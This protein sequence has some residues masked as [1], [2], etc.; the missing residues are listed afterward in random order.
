MSTG[1]PKNMITTRFD[2]SNLDLWAP[3]VRRAADLLN[4]ASVLLH[5]ALRALRKGLSELTAPSEP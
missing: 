5:L 2:G 1:I 3:Q 4:V